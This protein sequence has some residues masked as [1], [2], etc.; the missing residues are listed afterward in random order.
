MNEIYGGS[1]HDTHPSRPSW[2]SAATLRDAAD[3]Y[4]HMTHAKGGPEDLPWKTNA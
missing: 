3:G 1:E 4:C 2:L